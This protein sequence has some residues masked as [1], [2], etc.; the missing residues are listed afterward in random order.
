[1]SASFEYPDF[2]KILAI[3]NIEYFG[4]SWEIFRSKKPTNRAHSVLV[5]DRGFA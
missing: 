3:L 1:M 5:V 4:E 2:S